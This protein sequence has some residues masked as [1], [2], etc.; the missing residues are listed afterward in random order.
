MQGLRGTVRPRPPYPTGSGLW[1]RPTAVNNVE[2]LA[3]VPWVLRHGGAAYAKLGAPAETGTKLVCLSQRFR[4]P[5]VYEVELVVPLR[6]LVDALG[7]GVEP[8]YRLRCLQVCGPLGGFL[9]PDE[10]DL[11]LLGDALADAGV[12]LGHGSLVAVDDRITAH[13]LLRHVWRFAAAE[14]CGACTPC[15]VGTRR[16]LELTGDSAGARTV[17][18]RQ[19][20]LLEVMA[21]GSLCA[22][23]RGVPTAVRS[24]VRVY[25]D[26]LLAGE[27]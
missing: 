4:N 5:G 18:S 7:G 27:P 2:T 10:L 11:P 12:A 8:G 3:A 22:F 19:D 15:R 25:R 23:G 16:G 26:E 9:S 17:L 20:D 21:T 14:S 1:G 24:L 13:E 6:Y